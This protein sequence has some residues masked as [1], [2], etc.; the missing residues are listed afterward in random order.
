MPLSYIGPDHLVYENSRKLAHRLTDYW[1]KLGYNDV[2]ATTA[3]AVN[4][5]NPNQVA[6]GVRSNLINGLPPSLY[7]Q[8]NRGGTIPA[9]IVPT[10]RPP[11]RRRMR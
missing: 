11:W 2:I 9:D 4:S 8:V 10:S 7:A 6:Y 5:R 1:A 3:I